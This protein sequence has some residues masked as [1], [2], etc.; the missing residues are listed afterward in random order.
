VFA[1]I[2]E[3]LRAVVAGDATRLFPLSPRPVGKAVSV[4]VAAGEL[5]D[6]VSILRIKQQRIADPA[7]RANV[8][9]ELG[10]LSAV[11]ADC[12]P[13]GEGL[14]S[15]LAELTVI[16]GRLWEIEDEIRD[17]D[18]RGDFGPR[19]IE[20]ARSVYQTNDRRAAVKRRIDELLGSPLTE[21]KQYAAY[22]REHSPHGA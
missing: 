17:C 15:L 13:D 4:S 7:R 20:L 1:R 11:F 19:F 10:Q 6:K 21:E 22:D 8:E 3:E 9:R 14:R 12:L 18:A 5:C 16:N 2:A